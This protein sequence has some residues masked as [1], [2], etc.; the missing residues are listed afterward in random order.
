MTIHAA[1]VVGS[2][3]VFLLLF[4][5]VLLQMERLVTTSWIYLTLNLVGAALACL[6]SAMIGFL[7]FVVLEGVWALSSTVALIKLVSSEKVSEEGIS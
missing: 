1:D 4:A 7:P 2:I 6:S 3:G 5:F